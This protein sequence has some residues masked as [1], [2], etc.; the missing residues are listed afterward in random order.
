MTST[1]ED[2][3]RAAPTQHVENCTTQHRSPCL[4]TG[5]A[6]VRPSSRASVHADHPHASNRNPARTAS[7]LATQSQPDS[8]AGWTWSLAWAGRGQGPRGT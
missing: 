4:F 2:T 8:T 3:P 7:S 6:A 1:H 5:I